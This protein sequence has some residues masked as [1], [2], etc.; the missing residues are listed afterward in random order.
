MSAVV[1]GSCS[2][3]WTAELRDAFPH[4]VAQATWRLV[5]SRTSLRSTGTFAPF[6]LPI[7]RVQRA[8]QWPLWNQR[9]NRGWPL[10]TGGRDAHRPEILQYRTFHVYLWTLREG[11]HDH[12]TCLRF[13]SWQAV[14]GRQCLR[15]IVLVSSGQIAASAAKASLEA[16]LVSHGAL[17]QKA[18]SKE[19]WI[20]I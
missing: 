8:W 11:V 6:F 17:A 7:E 15:N 3:F 10:T 20:Y 16:F 9:E 18:P 1:F 13:A 14:C 5:E 2:W 12:T 4:L 19:R